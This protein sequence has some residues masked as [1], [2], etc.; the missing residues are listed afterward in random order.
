[1]LADGTR[2]G[3]LLFL[4]QGAVDVVEDGWHIAGSPS[5]ARFSATWGRFGT[6]LIRP[7][8]LRSSLRA[9]SCGS[10]SW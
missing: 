7:T 9:F 3:R 6:N 10:K 1:V 4:I 8:L 2:T 5:P